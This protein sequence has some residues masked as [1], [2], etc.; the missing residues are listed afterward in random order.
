[1]QKWIFMENFGL[2]FWSIAIEGE[3][4]PPVVWPG[5]KKVTGADSALLIDSTYNRC[6]LGEPL[7]KAWELPSAPGLFDT[8]ECPKVSY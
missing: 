4:H 7:T 6:K 2:A 1:M 8:I 3:Q 5:N